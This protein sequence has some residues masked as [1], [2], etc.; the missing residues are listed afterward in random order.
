MALREI[1]QK[2]FHIG[3]KINQKLI[4]AKY[5]STLSDND[6]ENLRIF[7]CF[8]NQYSNTLLYILDQLGHCGRDERLITL[9]KE[10]IQVQQEFNNVEEVRGYIID[11]LRHN[12]DRRG[13][14]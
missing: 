8:I 12:G 2:F 1:L 10:H 7:S 14:Y 11:F 13:E 6:E 3:C 5:V 9:I 4:A